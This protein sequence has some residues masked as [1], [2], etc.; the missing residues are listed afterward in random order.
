MNNT[1]K[2]NIRIGGITIGVLIVLLGIAIGIA[3][4]FIFTPKKLTPVV[5]NMVNNSSFAS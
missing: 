3:V 1:V 2:R 4:N 5:V